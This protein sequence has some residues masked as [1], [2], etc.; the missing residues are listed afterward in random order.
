MQGLTFPSEQEPGVKFPNAVL[1]FPLLTEIDTTLRKRPMSR[2]DQVKQQDEQLHVSMVH[3]DQLHVSMVR[4]D[5]L[6][7]SMI[8][9][10]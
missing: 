2:S 7:V 6:H 8:H 5:Q 9:D 4:D 3:N 1:V 10:V